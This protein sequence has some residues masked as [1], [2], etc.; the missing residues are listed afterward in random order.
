MCVYVCA[1]VRACVCVCV[2]VCVIRI[3]N[4]ISTKALFI[5]YYANLL[6]KIRERSQ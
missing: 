5:L 4:K 6:I 1:Y 3:F 2:F